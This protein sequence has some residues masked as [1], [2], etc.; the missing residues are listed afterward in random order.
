MLRM[1]LCAMPNF[2]KIHLLKSDESLRLT[3]YRH[4]GVNLSTLL[5]PNVVL[6]VRI[7][8]RQWYH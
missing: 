2:T 7:V 1:L 8:V 3:M 6:S 5:I 4:N